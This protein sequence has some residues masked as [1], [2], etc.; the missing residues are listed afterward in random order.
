[1]NSDRSSLNNVP[2]KFGMEFLS[3]A[4]CLE[5]RSPSKMTCGDSCSALAISVD[6]CSKKRCGDC[7]GER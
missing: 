1:M 5:F 3:Q 7:D 4:W 2:P 6:R